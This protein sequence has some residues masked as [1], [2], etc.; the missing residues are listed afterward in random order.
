MTTLFSGACRA[1]GSLRTALLEFAQGQDAEA[2]HG[3][4]VASRLRSPAA[5]G[6]DFSPVDIFTRFHNLAIII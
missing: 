2:E 1:S 4:A 6:I 5:C 3:G